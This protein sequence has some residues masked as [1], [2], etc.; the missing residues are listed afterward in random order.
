MFY[1]CVKIPN[2]NTNVAAATVV[3]VF[4]VGIFV[5]KMSVILFIA[6]LI[7]GEPIFQTP[8]FHL[9]QKGPIMGNTATGAD[10]IGIYLSNLLIGIPA[11]LVMGGAFVCMVVYVICYVF[12][13]V[14]IFINES[15]NSAFGAYLF[16]DENF[17]M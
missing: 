17:K 4:R 12:W 10:S 11:L 13:F 9:L 16:K 8:I 2:I 3:N 15:Y 14:L 6:W 1:D 7:I 5:L